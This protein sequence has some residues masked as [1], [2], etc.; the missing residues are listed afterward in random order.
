MLIAK[1][2]TQRFF[3]HEHSRTLF[4]NLSFQVARGERLA[5]L[6][7]N[8]QGKSTLIKILGGV[9]TPTAGTVDWRM[10][11]SWPLAFS[12]A[13]HGSLTGMD[14][15]LFVSRIYR[16]PIDEVIRR[17]ED[18]AE[19]GEAL[20]QP[21]KF[22]SSGMRARLAFGLSLAI[23]FDCYLIDEV[24]FVGD[25]LFHQKCQEELFNKRG[26]RAFVIATHDL[27]FVR[28][29]CERA[30]VIDRGQA[31]LFND[32]EEAIDIVWKA[33]HQEAAQT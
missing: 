32:V 8:G 30:I 18:F 10:T 12:G 3:L 14:N 24:I 9:L 31:T 19:L 20:T 7:R 17:T 25:M 6:G 21:I 16:R 22:Y 33:A 4:E 28:D 29:N 2:L 13:F 27:Q 15:I 11:A 23:E 1:G 5:V 26:G